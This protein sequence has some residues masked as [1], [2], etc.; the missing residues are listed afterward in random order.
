M[1]TSNGLLPFIIVLIVLFVIVLIFIAF[2]VTRTSRRDV[3]THN[4]DPGTSNIN[5][6]T[7]TN[8]P[9]ERPLQNQDDVNAREEVR[10]NGEMRR[11]NPGI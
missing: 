11:N 9:E 7:A 8:Q 10:P 6:H 1:T 4:S 3:S 5:Q 2:A